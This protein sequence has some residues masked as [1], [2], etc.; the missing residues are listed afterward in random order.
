MRKIASIHERV[1]SLIQLSDFRNEFAGLSD[2][3]AAE[4]IKLYGYNSETK[5]DEK[6]KGFSPVSVFLK[7]RFW[8]M[9]AA[10]VICF[11]YG[12]YL[13]GAVLAALTA[14]YAATEIVKG[15]KC[16]RYFFEQKKTT[17]VD[18]NVVRGG[19]L[20][21]IRRELLVPDDI[22]LLEAG[23]NV[24][25]DA[26]LL[27]INDL[28]VDESLFTGSKT[29]AAKITGADSLSEE[30]KKSCVYKGTKIVSGR[31]AARVT[32]TG[33][34]TRYFKTFGAEKAEERY[35]TATEKTVMRVS[36][37]LTLASAV[38][39]AFAA[40]FHF[41]Q[42]DI[43]AENPVLDTIYNTFYPAIS[44]ALCFIP[45]ELASIIRIYCIKGSEQ[46]A[47]RNVIIKDLKV[48][49]D[50]SAV[51]CICV[52]KSGMITNNHM[53]VVDVL[54]ANPEMMTNISVLAC[55]KSG[56]PA[57]TDK[58]IILNAAFTGADVKGLQEN[59]LIKEYPFAS[60]EGAAGN[61]WSINGARLLCIKGSPEKLLP[62]CDIPADMLYTVQNKIISY[63]KQGCHV[64]AAAFSPLPEGSE[65]PE[66]VHDVRYSFMGLIAFDNKTKDNIPFAIRSCYKSGIRVIMTTGD[67]ADTAVSIAEKIGIKETGVI[68]GEQ[69][70]AAKESGIKPDL[71]GVGIFARI[72]PEQKADIISLLQESGELV[73]VSGDAGTNSDILEQADFAVALGGAAGGAMGEACGVVMADE[74]FESVVDVF[75]I[76]R[77]VYA[78]IKRCISTHITAI[79]TLAI[80]AVVNM[81]LGTTFILSPV[82][83][84]LITIVGVPVISLMFL[85]INTDIRGE[86]RPS[87]FHGTGR[88]TKR[89][90]VRPFIQAL[91][92]CASEIVLYLISSGFGVNSRETIENLSGQSAANF[93]LILIFGLIISGWIN[94]SEKGVLDAIK[95]GQAYAAIISGSCILA[96]LLLV[97]VPYLNTAVGLASVNPMMA[98][99]ALV[100]TLVL[101][102]PAEAIK[103]SGKK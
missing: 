58:A 44:F 22:L 45:S 46:L 62:L 102:I 31:L 29:P 77:Q 84:L 51:T 49:E 15:Q 18:Y 30:L 4:H 93:L 71:T 54:T 97:F 32:G 101:Q 24:P 25:A 82:L 66:S 75:R 26:H 37:I 42:I 91:G 57:P 99:I 2:E 38:M 23:E 68:T 8:L 80:F 7:L 73:A 81:L 69:L 53:E 100:I 61:L 60:S 17:R 13:T 86:Q 65:P 89:F 28:L 9:T 21:R 19:E 103:Y 67:S 83:V 95:S 33:V 40:L 47:E 16:D 1:F 48:I 55:A 94:M 70:A 74:D 98:V 63:E 85:E 36:R 35:Y 14:A 12:E 92:L 52:D 87:G 88:I 76:G 34:D 41:S 10:A 39:L 56:D 11:L 43:Y 50:L 20:R 79:T 3:K 78:N 6:E 90:F 64:L 27:E 59:E 72:T 96:A 5:L